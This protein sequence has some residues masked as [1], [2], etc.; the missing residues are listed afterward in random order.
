MPPCTTRK[1]STKNKKQIHP[2]HAV[3]KPSLMAAGKAS[4]KNKKPKEPDHAHIGWTP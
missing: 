4:A 2:D 3:K 1:S